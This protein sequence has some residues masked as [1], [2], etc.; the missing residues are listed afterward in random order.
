MAQ[1]RA[2]I[3]HRV[4]LT[5]DE[6]RTLEQLVRHGR[7]AGWKL[8]RAQALL[9]SGKLADDFQIVEAKRMIHVLNAPSPAATASIAI[10]E[11]IAQ[12][13]F[14]SFELD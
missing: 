2:T 11:T 12:R 8:R 6:R 13:A 7:A 4:K 3:K 9:K 1:G 14:D 10:G 5:T